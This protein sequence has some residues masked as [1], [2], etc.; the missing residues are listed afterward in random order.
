[1]KD[2]R[3]CHKSLINYWKSAKQ[4]G[5]FQRTKNANVDLQ[6]PGNIKSPS[7]K[8]NNS[9]NVITTTLIINVLLM[10]WKLLGMLILAIKNSMLW[11]LPELENQSI[12]GCK[13]HILCHYVSSLRESYTLHKYRFSKIQCI[14][15]TTCKC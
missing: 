5:H 10:I 14:N 3:S 6:L 7:N 13:N 15:N 4:G 1:M 9:Y 11:K 8:L 12:S 2:K